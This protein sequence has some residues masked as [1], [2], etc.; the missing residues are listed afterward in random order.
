MNESMTPTDNLSQL[1][2]LIMTQIDSKAKTG[3]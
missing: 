1:A 2:L 3:L